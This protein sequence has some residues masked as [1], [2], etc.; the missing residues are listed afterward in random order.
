MDH[1]DLLNDVVKNMATTS[2]E[3]ENITSTSEAVDYGNETIDIQLSTG[4]TYSI[5]VSEFDWDLAVKNLQLMDINI[6]NINVLVNALFSTNDDNPAVAQLKERAAELQVEPV[7]LVISELSKFLIS[8]NV[9][10]NYTEKFSNDIPMETI[11]LLM[12]Y[13]AQIIT[14][15][16]HEHVTIYNAMVMF[17]SA[18][19]EID[20]MLDSLHDDLPEEVKQYANDDIAISSSNKELMY[21]EGKI[22]ESDTGIASL[23]KDSLSVDIRYDEAMDPSKQY[24][25]CMNDNETV[26]VFVMARSTNEAISIATDIFNEFVND[27]NTTVT[28]SEE[29]TEDSMSYTDLMSSFGINMGIDDDH[30]VS[31]LIS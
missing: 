13:D 12:A 28:V 17:R 31:G 25:V 5:K 23:V 1:K 9:T 2:T 24:I 26:G 21:V 16:L 4:D 22:E 19:N 7:D 15:T 27:Y 18:D 6:H 3:E 14:R 11:A 10:F 8:Y 30:D 29:E 20:R